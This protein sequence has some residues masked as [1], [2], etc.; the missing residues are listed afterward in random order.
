M[1]IRTEDWPE[2]KRFARQIRRL[3]KLEYNHSV[4]FK[5]LK[6]GS[7]LRIRN[8]GVGYEVYIK[9][10]ANFAFAGA[11]V[12]NEKEHRTA[13]IKELR[14]YVSRDAL[15]LLQKIINVLLSTPGL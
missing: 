13:D 3:R 7:S 8:I 4:T 10:E 9:D 12:F 11:S 5:D 6:C 14:L 2:I 15:P 1:E